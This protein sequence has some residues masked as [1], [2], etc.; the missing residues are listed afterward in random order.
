MLNHRVLL[1]ILD[2]YGIRGVANKWFESYLTLRKQC[3]EIKSKKQ[4]TSVSTT[5][6][7]I[8]GV[9]QG[10]TLGPIL[11]LLYIN[12]LPL[13]VLESNIVLFAD[14]TNLLITGDN[15]NTVQSRTNNVMQDIRSWFISNSSIVNAGK[16]LAISFHTTQN[17]IPAVPRVILEDREI[18]YN[19][20]TK[21]L[22]VYLNEI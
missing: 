15:L 3:V 16:T 20:E 12:D 8:H 10:S 17:K 18:P 14:D 22:G 13:N 6:E 1:S 5:K 21:F 7:I 2:T 4:G 19:T 9:P 11:F